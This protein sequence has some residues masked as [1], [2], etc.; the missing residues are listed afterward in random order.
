MESDEKEGGDMREGRGKIWS[1]LRIAPI[2][3]LPKKEKCQK[4]TM[5]I[6]IVCSELETEPFGEFLK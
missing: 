6:H 4:G 1:C 2:K 3:V 5:L